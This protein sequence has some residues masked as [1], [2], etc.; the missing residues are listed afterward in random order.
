[1]WQCWHCWSQAFGD[2]PLKS[3]SIPW[4][5]AS[6]LGGRWWRRGVWNRRVPK[7]RTAKAAFGRRAPQPGARRR[8]L[9]SPA[10]QSRTTGGGFGSPA[11]QAESQAEGL[12]RLL[13]QGNR[14]RRASLVYPLSAGGKAQV[15]GRCSGALGPRQT[16]S[17]QSY[18]EITLYLQVSDGERQR[19]A[20]LPSLG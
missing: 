13:P 2:V 10:P 17:P 8:L 18:D 3:K 14:R 5:F 6:L 12:G 1:M 16:D 15:S 4:G 7:G 20:A 11:P 9:L 19:E